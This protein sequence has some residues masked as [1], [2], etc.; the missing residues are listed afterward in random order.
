MKQS[1]V[2]A[3]LKALPM[4]LHYDHAPIGTRVPFATVTITA[5]NNFSA[6]DSVYIGGYQVRLTVYTEKKNAATEK[7]VRDIL[8]E[9]GF[10]WTMDESFVADESAI[11]QEYTFGFI[12]EA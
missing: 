11:A 10:V 7:A 1:D 6:D 5:P 12:G 3:K 8:N 4:P 2:I 9:N